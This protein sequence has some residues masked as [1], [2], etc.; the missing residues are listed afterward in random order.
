MVCLCWMVAGFGVPQW[1]RVLVKYVHASG[2]QC[3]KT[4]W[5]GPAHLRMKNITNKFCEEKFI[6]FVRFYVP[7]SNEKSDA[8]KT[9]LKIDRFF[10]NVCS[11]IHLRFCIK[12]GRKNRVEICRKNSGLASSKKTKVS[13]LFERN[14]HRTKMLNQ[15]L[16]DT[17]NYT[18]YFGLKIKTICPALFGVHFLIKN[19]NAKLFIETEKNLSVL[20][21]L[22]FLNKKTK[23]SYTRLKQ[24]TEKRLY[25]PNSVAT[26]KR[27]NTCISFLPQLHLFYASLITVFS[28][29]V[30]CS[31]GYFLWSSTFEKVSNT[32][33]VR[34]YL[35]CPL[36]GWDQ[37]DRCCFFNFPVY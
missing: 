31:S 29:L 19:E 20:T 17:D 36:L 8:T 9:I 2:P 30:C 24:E 12:T 22:R 13:A 18:A 34:L 28:L 1:V 4:F 35:R 23:W 3:I 5:G 26:I 10:E 14:S 37:V 11:S 6:F 21:F 16:L 7:T 25:K 33:N 27:Q 32:W 15:F